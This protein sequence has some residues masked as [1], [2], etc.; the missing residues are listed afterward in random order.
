MNQ[1]VNET[2]MNGPL[3]APL[4]IIQAE[5]GLML[6]CRTSWRRFISRHL[7]PPHPTSRGT[8]QKDQEGVKMITWSE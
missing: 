8:S 1:E 6:L 7:P 2:V 5:M 3:E 4:M